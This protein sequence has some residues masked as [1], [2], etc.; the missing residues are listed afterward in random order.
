[1]RSKGKALVKSVDAKPYGRVSM[2]SR[3]FKLLDKHSFT[4]AHELVFTLQRAHYN[5]TS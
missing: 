4:N 1:L 2:A 3:D 5:T